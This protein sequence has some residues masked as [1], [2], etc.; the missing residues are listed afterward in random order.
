MSQLY[1]AVAK[2]V[3]LYVPENLVTN[4]DLTK[5]VNTSDEWIQSRSGI[6]QR[7][8]VVE[9]QTTS[10]LAVAACEQAIQKAN[11]KPTDVDLVL[12]AT[13]SPDYYFP[14]IGVLIQKKMGLR[15]VPAIDVRGQCAGFSWG[16]S[17]ADAYARM[18]SYKNIL[19]VGAEAQSVALDYS[20][21]GRH[22]AVLFGDGAGAVLF[23]AEGCEV[24]EFPTA[25]NNRRGVIDHVMG[26]DGDGAE[27]LVLRRP[28]MS[29][30]SNFLTHDDIEQKNTF[31][32]MDGKL[33]FK[34]AVT[35]MSNAVYELL[36]RNG[37]KL[38][39]IDLLVPHQ[40]NAR[41][42]EMLR[43]KLGLPSEKVVSVIEKY[44]NTTAATIPMCMHE[45]VND[46]RLK[47][48]TLV[49]SVAF[50]SGFAWGANLIRW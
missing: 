10:D 27:A 45:A 21:D 35:R 37:L 18:G 28:G 8:H 19:V 4:D 17:M 29:G 30:P 44:G 39:D 36:D 6:K 11:I 12:A 31:P 24:S 22:I 1:K 9:G 23:Q 48:G 25:R 26:T 32:H 20:D 15:N 49:V 5:K 46:G 43:S 41:I 42:N 3:G 33:V 16:I 14:G 50:G 34:N 40:A 38:E 2:T 13:L 47:E 7:Y